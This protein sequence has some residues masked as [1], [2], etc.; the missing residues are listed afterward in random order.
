MNLVIGS[1][2]MAFELKEYI[3]AHLLEQGH[4][5]TDLGTLDE[6][7]P[8]FYIDVADNVAKAIQSGAYDFGILICNTGM[9]VSLV[10]NKHKGVY[11]ALCESEWT[12]RK[13]RRINNANILSRGA[14]VVGKKMAVDMVETFI[15]T[16]FAENEPPQRVE[17]LSS[18]LKMIEAMEEKEFR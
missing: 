12:A 15:H 10:A 13:S 18:Y 6:E 8:V 2:S 17:L 3:K 16:P 1:E 9:G 5:V 11:C 7:H 4:Q 14:A